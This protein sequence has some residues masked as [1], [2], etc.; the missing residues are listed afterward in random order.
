[1]ICFYYKT[2][3]GYRMVR[4]SINA[5]NAKKQDCWLENINRTSRSKHSKQGKKFIFNIFCTNL[6][7]TF[8]SFVLFFE[9][10]DNNLFCNVNL[11]HV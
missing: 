4:L 6:V 8:L 11:L 5:I 10:F 2:F 7:E 9:S 3:P 1:M